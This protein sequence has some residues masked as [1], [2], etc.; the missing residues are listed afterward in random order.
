MEILRKFIPTG[1]YKISILEV[2]Y[3]IAGVHKF[4][5]LD[6]YYVAPHLII[7]LNKF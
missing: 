7:F 5:G 1:A 4:A 2:L 6:T 3:R